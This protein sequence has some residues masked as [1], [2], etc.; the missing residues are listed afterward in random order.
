MRTLATLAATLVLTA[1]GGTT[2]PSGKLL[3][4]G[5]FHADIATISFTEATLSMEHRMDVDEWEDGVVVAV[6]AALSMD[7]G[8]TLELEARGCPDAMGRVPL[9]SVL[10]RPDAFCPGWPQ[11][12]E[13]LYLPAEGAS[14]GYAQLADVQVPGREKEKACFGTQVEFHLQGL[15]QSAGTGAVLAVQPSVMVIEG[16]V[17]SKGSY[18]A[19][20]NCRTVIDTDLCE[21]PE[22]VGTEEVAES[23][24]GP[25]SGPTVTLHVECPDCEEG[26]ALRLHASAGW[27]IG[28][29]QYT[30]VFQKATFPF[31]MV[32]PMAED[33][34]GLP[35]YWPGGNVSFRAWQDTTP[36]GAVPEEG[37][38][39][40]PVVTK[41][42]VDGHLNKVELT[43]DTTGRTTVDC[44]P[45]SDFCLSLQASA[46]CNGT[47]DGYEPVTCE[48]GSACSEV[49][50][51]C[52]EVICAPSKVICAD[53]NAY[54]KCLA[55]GTG[56]SDPVSCN[57]GYACLNGN[58][59]KE[60][61]F[62]EVVFLVDTS[63]SMAMDWQAAANSLAALTS[64]SPTAS[65]GLMTFPTTNAV[66]KLSTTPAVPPKPDQGEAILGWFEKNNAFGQT[67][68]L[69][70][71]ETMADVLPDLFTTPSG[72][73]VL[74]SDGADTCAYPELPVEDREALIVQGLGAA[75]QLLFQDH[76][77]K[78]YVIGYQF[79]GN[80]EQLTAIAAN[81]GTGKSTYTEAGNE[82]ELTNVLVAIGQDLKLC[83]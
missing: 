24:A 63:A 80:P 53:S 77:I 76:G 74:L 31:D 8:C 20:A 21:A 9:V 29:A 59:M 41:E 23:D 71:M 79:Q 67:P 64:M 5:V 48:E 66:C 44:V 27:E 1:C 38:P 4:S 25:T 42:L 55:S 39:V 60:E 14:L 12:N 75:T 65:F 13:G 56:Y 15:L 70:A 16:E 51:L 10:F 73:L 49:T 46:H 26:S 18:A 69:L 68:L 7:R 30:L 78:T 36:G 83:F 6:D 43:L 28:V 50:G 62:A 33:P 11:E 81:G 54:R 37:E 17:R 22:E 58:C 40:S 52:A 35:V 72:A 57:E 47:G 3:V 45:D 34:A 19:R 61:C 2:C 82:E 32:L